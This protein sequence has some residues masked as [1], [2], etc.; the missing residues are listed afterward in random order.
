MCDPLVA[1]ALYYGGVR[2]TLLEILLASSDA[3]IYLSADNHFL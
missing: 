3:G 2:A 1:V